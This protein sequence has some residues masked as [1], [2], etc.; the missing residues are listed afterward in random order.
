[1]IADHRF[2]MLFFEM[3]AAHLQAMLEEC[4]FA[5]LLAFLADIDAFLHMFILAHG[6]LL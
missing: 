1:M 5:D 6:N 2:H 3:F 4:F